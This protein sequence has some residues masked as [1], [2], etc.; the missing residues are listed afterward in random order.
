MEDLFHC[1][2][3]E[4]QKEVGDVYAKQITILMVVRCETM[5]QQAKSQEDGNIQTHNN[6]SIL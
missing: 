5:L 6:Y 1:S 3:S 2:W 4:S